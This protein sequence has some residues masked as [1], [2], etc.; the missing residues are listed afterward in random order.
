VNL[1]PV[2]P[3]A[4][5]GCRKPETGKIQSFAEKLTRLGLNATVRTEMGSDVAGACG[6]LRRKSIGS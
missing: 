5:T 4:E 3:V 1:I 6:Q 2:N